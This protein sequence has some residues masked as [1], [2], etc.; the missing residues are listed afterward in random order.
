MKRAL[1]TITFLFLMISFASAQ[2][3]GGMGMEHGMQMEGGMEREQKKMQPV[4]LTWLSG[5]QLESDLAGLEPSLSLIVLHDG[6][7]GSERYRP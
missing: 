2:P 5:C 7:K 1:F 4:Q 3:G 6:R